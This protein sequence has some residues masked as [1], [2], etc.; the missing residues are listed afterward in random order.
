MLARFVLSGNP[1]NP[2]S[3]LEQTVNIISV[4]IGVVAVIGVIPMYFYWTWHYCVAV[5]KVTKHEFTAGFNFA[6]AILL[7]LFSVGFL[8]PPIVQY[9]FNKLA[10]RRR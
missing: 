4:L 6:L 3:S 5:E 10:P 8:W 9:Q 2:Q 7:A 1:A